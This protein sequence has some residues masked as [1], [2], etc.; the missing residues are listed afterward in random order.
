MTEE[1]PSHSSVQVHLEPED[2]AFI[3]RQVES[4]VYAS[5]EDMLREGLRLLARNERQQRVAALRLMIDEA[6]ESV[7]AG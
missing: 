5:A 6:D 1:H 3:Q 7:E 4:G 2:T